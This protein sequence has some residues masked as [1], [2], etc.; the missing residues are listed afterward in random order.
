M[1]DAW[2]MYEG[3]G[4]FG[5]GESKRFTEL[6]E[7]EQL[8]KCHP[9]VKRFL[10]YAKAAPVLHPFVQPASGTALKVR[11]AFSTNLNALSTHLNSLSTHLNAF[12]T[13]LNVKVP[14]TL[15]TSGVY[16][17]LTITTLQISLSL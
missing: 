9:Q 3:T 12:D 17:T 14:D 16:P 6:L 15:D 5:V 11:G 13:H 2:R 10:R 1:L 8:A 4:C 7:D